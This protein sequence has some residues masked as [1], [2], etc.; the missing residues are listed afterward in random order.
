MTDD[1]DTPTTAD[2]QRV[3]REKANK[4]VALLL[5]GVS[6]VFLIGAIGVGLLVL[7]GPY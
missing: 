4:L 5:V 1:T 3:A 2:E 7:Y 6:V